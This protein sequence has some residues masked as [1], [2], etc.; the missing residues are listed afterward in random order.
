VLSGAGAEGLARVMDAM[1][2]GVLDPAARAAL[3]VPDDDEP[4]T[5]AELAGMAE[6]EAAYA[7]GDVVDVDALR[8]ELAS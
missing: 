7:T 2:A 6:A 4:V 8:T 3:L 1:A 5:A